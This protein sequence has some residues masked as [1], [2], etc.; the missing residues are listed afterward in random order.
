MILNEALIPYVNGIIILILVGFT[1]S[2]FFSGLVNQFFSLFSVL[3]A[4]IVAFLFC[5]PFSKLLRLVNIPMNNIPSEALN[6][7]LLNKLNGVVWFI[8]IFVLVL[9]LLSFTRRVFHVVVSLPIIKLLNKFLGAFFGFAK[10]LV[11]LFL[12]SII[13]TMPFFMNGMEFKSKTFFTYLDSAVNSALVSDLFTE[14]LA[15]QSFLNNPEEITEDQM[16]WLEQW[17]SDAGYSF[18][19]IQE[20]IDE[21]QGN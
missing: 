17:L 1:I 15:I 5:G 3:V 16:L 21:M 13:L 18:G 19:E 12:V 10:A 8:L 11:V 14:G 9:I 7:I 20:I 6:E 2:G 4:A